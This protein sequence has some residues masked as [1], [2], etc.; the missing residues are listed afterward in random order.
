M[1]PALSLLATL[2][3]LGVVFT[4][5]H[6]LILW[7]NLPDLA[8]LLLFALPVAAYIAWCT[9][10]SRRAQ[11]RLAIQT[12]LTFSSVTIASAAIVYFID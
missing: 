4:L 6:W 3:M 2:T 9:A 5:L 10:D 7:L 8:A 1:A 12:Y 11:L